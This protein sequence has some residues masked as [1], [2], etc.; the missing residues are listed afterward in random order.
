MA[1]SSGLRPR[2]RIVIADDSVLLREGIASLLNGSGYDVVGQAGD[3]DR[4]VEIVRDLA[5]DLA[6]I[7]I[8]MPP[9]HTWEGIE[10]AKII[11]SESPSIGILLLSAHVE[12]ETAID[13]LE[14]SESIGYLLKDR[15]MKVADL[16]DA[17]ERIAEGGSVVDPAIVLELFS[18]KTKSDPLAQLTAREMDVLALVAE[19]RS[20]SAIAQRLFVSEGAVEKHVRSIL[21]KLQLPTNDEDHRRVLAVLTFLGAQ[22]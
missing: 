2:N 6:I 20:N 19:G 18:Q 5:P 9:T 12:L 10:V 14:S 21:T 13:L 11:R 15:V 16:I 4:L 17:L 22:P 7:D 8:R 1:S 3:G